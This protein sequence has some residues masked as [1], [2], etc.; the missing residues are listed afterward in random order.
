MSDHD[1]VGGPKV[2]SYF[3]RPGSQAGAISFVGVR[4]LTDQSLKDQCDINK[5]VERFV[6]SGMWPIPG[7]NAPELE[8]DA[9]DIHPTLQDQLQLVIDAK[10]RFDALPASVRSR[11]GNDLEALISFVADSNNRDQA[12]ALGLIPAA[13]A[14]AASSSGQLPDSSRGGNNGNPD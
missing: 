7:Q 4:D 5:I 2:R 13:P 11:F 3:T 12:V 14:G 8:Y 6:D 9:F 1:Q 10:E